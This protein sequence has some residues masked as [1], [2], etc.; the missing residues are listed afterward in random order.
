MVGLTWWFII[1]FWGYFLMQL[2]K[3]LNLTIFKFNKHENIIGI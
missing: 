1:C 2:K 3:I